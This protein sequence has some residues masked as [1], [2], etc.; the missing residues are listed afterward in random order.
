MEESTFKNM[1]GLKIFTRAWRPKEKETGVIVIVPGFNS[2]GGYY[3]WVADRLVE[4]G[5]AAYAIDLQGRGRSDGKRFFVSSFDDYVSDVNEFIKL[6]KS[7][8]PDLPVF[9]LGHSAGGVVSCLYTINNQIELA[10]LICESFAFHLPAP[11]FALAAFKG[12]EHIAPNSHFLRLKNENFSRDPEVIEF[13]NND[14]LI[15]G[16]SQPTQT[17]AELVR[18]DDYLKN[19][20]KL[21]TL[22][23]LILHGTGDKAAKVSGSEYFYENTNST[24][25]TLKIYEGGYHDLLND[26]IKEEVM[27]DVLSWIGKRINDG[28]KSSVVSAKS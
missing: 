15:A 7:K 28:K 1:N 5:F 20:L 25:P 14:P 18:A 26:I 3:S 22:P 10:G 23:V 24:D 13:M 21:I 9:I 27:H 17:L 12:L 2:H 8:E 19:N 11:G 16:E 4:N 6:I